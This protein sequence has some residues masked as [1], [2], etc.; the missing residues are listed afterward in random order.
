LLLEDLVSFCPGGIA[1]DYLEGVWPDFDRG[2]WLDEQVEIPVRMMWGARERPEYGP[3]AIDLLID[4]WIHSL[5]SGAPSFVTNKDDGHPGKR[6]TD[7]AAVRPK[8][9]D[10]LGIEVDLIWHAR[11]LSA[12]AEHYF[13]RVDVGKTPLTGLAAE[14][15][16]GAVRNPDVGSAG[17][18]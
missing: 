3:T 4:E 13:G 18:F 6:S 15:E 10:N 2:P 5:S 17:A 1:R 8:F 11:S 16:D 9:L 7:T 12:P 14:L